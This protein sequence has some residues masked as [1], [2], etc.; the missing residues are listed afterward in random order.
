MM[1]PVRLLRCD[2]GCDR[3][4]VGR[5]SR[6]GG[7]LG[8]GVRGAAAPRARIPRETAAAAALRPRRHLDPRLSPDPRAETRDAETLRLRRPTRRHD[9]RGE[10][11]GAHGRDG[12]SPRRIT[13]LLPPAA[14]PRPAAAAAAAPGA[15]V[16]S[17]RCAFWS[18]RGVY[19]RH[20]AAAVA[21]A[22]ARGTPAWKRRRT[23]IRGETRRGYPP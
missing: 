2:R 10:A 11:A 12:G 22:A 13:W 15:D 5:L 21:A 9:S 7:G 14:D 4:G 17:P 19:G 3:G 6:R 23:L 20:A 8:E 18:R 16:P 1:K